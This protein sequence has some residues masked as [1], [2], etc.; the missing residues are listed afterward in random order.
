L[1]PFMALDSLKEMYLHS[2]VAVDDQFDG[3]VFEWKFPGLSSALTRF[4]FVSSCISAD[5]LSSLVAHTPNLAVLKY[6]HQTKFH[7]CE[8]D[9]NPGA[10]VEALARHCS[11]TIVEVA[12]TIDE[13][14]GDI[15]NGASSF[16]ALPNIKKLEVDVQ[17]FCGPPVESGQRRGPDARVPDG[18]RPWTSEDIPC[19]GSMMPT[20]IREV[21]I[22]TDEFG[23]TAGGKIACARESHCTPV[24]RG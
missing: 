22:N 20:G 24:R 8:Y 14:M 21:Q 16:L 1:Q 3:Y 9:W 2:A 17:V 15:I 18:E 23:G 7:G 10:F 13:L 19:I 4:E 6:S 11:N 12:I 5:G